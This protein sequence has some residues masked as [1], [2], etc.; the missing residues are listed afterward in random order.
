MSN[1]KKLEDVL[2]L[3]RPL[4]KSRFKLACEC[5]TK[6]FYTGKPNE[7]ANQSLEDSFL[8]NLAKGGFQVGA[9]AKLMFPGGTEITSLDYETAL[10]ETNE[11]LKKEEVIIYE[12]A[13]RFENLFI[14]AD[15]VCKKGDSLYLYEVKAKSYNTEEDHFW[16][17]R[18]PTK[19]N[20][21]WKE[22]LNDIAFQAFVVQK[23][24]P[25]LRLFPHLLLAD[26]LQKASVE[27]LNQNFKLVVKNGRDGVEVDPKL[28]PEGIGVPLLI[29][30]PVANEVSKIQTGQANG[31]EAPDWPKEF[32]F[33][34]YLKHLSDQYLNNKKIAPIISKECKGCEFKTDLKDKT[35]LKDGFLEC[36]SQA[37]QLSPEEIEKRRPVFEVWKVGAPKFMESGVYFMDQLQ[38]SDFEPKTKP[39]QTPKPGLQTKDRKAVQLRETLSNSPKPY[40]DKK[41]FLKEVADFTFPLHFIDFETSMVAIPFNKGR[42]PY[43]QIAFQFSHHTL[44]KD[45]TVRHEG[46]WILAE[47]GKFPN[48]DFVRALKKELEKDEGTIFRYA[49][50]ENAVLGQIRTQLKEASS[51]DVPD[52][53]D[54]IRFIESIA[55]PSKEEK[56]KWTAKREMVDMLDLVLRYFWHPR[57]KG[58]NSIK[59]VLPS[60]LEASP[61]LKDKYSKTVYGREAEIKSLNVE[62]SFAWVLLDE[63]GTPIDPYKRLPKVFGEFTFETMDRLFGDEELRDGGAAMMAYS[64]LQF[65]EM[66]KEEREAVT[67]ALLR[68]CELDTLAMV[69]L[70]EGWREWE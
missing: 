32:T 37:L 5:P 22:Y 41:G 6:L 43:E 44:Q 66:S 15:I 40:F 18:D 47:P 50:H 35:V 63:K 9:L 2:S 54:L 33:E 68:Y 55:R 12:A 8:K 23:S 59:V 11:L 38:E 1:A 36:W 27:G 60:I 56:D 62:G 39:K 53:E 13:F 26:K 29:A 34:S 51:T 28:T 30:V 42:G 3:K 7:Y 24:H 49:N 20:N 21:D 67:K 65:T 52:R 61:Y 57:M 17:K 19:M 14:R 70:W 48:F 58:S 10:R 64:K 69:M 46:Q 45:G 25:E 4:S 31:S 16:Q